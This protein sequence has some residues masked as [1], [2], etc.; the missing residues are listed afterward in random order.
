[1]N[2]LLD[3]N[4][5]WLS[6]PEPMTLFGNLVAIG[7][8][9]IVFYVCRLLT[10]QWMDEMTVKRM[11]MISGGWLIAAGLVFGGLRR[12]VER[13]LFSALSP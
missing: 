2:I 4:K 3:S 6:L 13:C 12:I 10:K 8:G 7:I 11:A 9:V 5:Y 1:M